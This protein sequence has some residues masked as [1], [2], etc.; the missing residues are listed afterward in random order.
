MHVPEGLKESEESGKN[1][2]AIGSKTILEATAERLY[3]AA[4]PLRNDTPN[5]PT[6]PARDAVSPG[7]F[8]AK[9]EQTNVPM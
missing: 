2:L 1:A 6:L 5:T 7:S 8:S 9:D 3:R 4:T